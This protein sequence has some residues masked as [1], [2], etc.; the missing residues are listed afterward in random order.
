MDRIFRTA[1]GL[2][3]NQFCKRIDGNRSNNGNYNNQNGTWRN[4]WNFCCSPS[5]QVQDF[6]QGLQFR[7]PQPIQ[8]R[9]SPIKW[10]DSNPNTSSSHKQN[11]PQSNIQ[12]STNVVRLNLNW[13]LHPR[14]IWTLPV[15]QLRSPASILDKTRNWKLSCDIFILPPDTRKKLTAWKLSLWWIQGFSA[16]YWTT[17]FFWKTCQLQHPITIQKSTHSIK[18]YSRQT[19]PMDGFANITFC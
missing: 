18:T 6:W 5:K 9:N 3:D 2:Q 14:A 19:V 4:I 1:D 8:P 13:W 12:P 17:D 10:S 15:K 7:R 16:Q 11:F